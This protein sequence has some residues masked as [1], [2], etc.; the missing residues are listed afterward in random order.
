MYDAHKQIWNPLL[1][2]GGCQGGHVPRHAATSIV[3][4]NSHLIF[5]CQACG[6]KAPPGNSSGRRGKASEAWVQ[7]S[8]SVSLLG[9]YRLG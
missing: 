2:P 8:Q 1:G 3:G 5:T 7:V 6:T 9:F 4:C